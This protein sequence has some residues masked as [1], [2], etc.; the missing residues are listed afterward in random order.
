MKKWIEDIREKT[1][2][3]DRSQKIEY[4]SSYYWYHILI[5]MILLGLV[6]LLA[7]HVGWGGRN[8]KEFTCVLVNQEVDLQRDRQMTEEFSA[9][10]GLDQKKILIDSDY[11]ISY[12][13]QI[14]EGVNESSYEKFFFNWSAGEIDAMVMPESFYDYCRKQNGEFAE[15]KL[16]VRDTKLREVLRDEEEDPVLLVFSAQAKQKEHCAAFLEYVKERRR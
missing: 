8:K 14:L 15:E 12:G 7:Y 4:I 11:L 6:L 1:K 9:F 5:G 2:N 13:D 16:Y 10:S 3:M